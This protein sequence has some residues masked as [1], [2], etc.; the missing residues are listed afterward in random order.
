MPSQ[1]Q[2]LSPIIFVLTVLA[3]TS[4][5]GAK[6]TYDGPDGEQHWPKHYPFCGGVFQSPIDLQTQLFRYDPTLPPIEVWNYNLSSH[7]QLTLDNNGH[8]VQLSLPPRMYLS[9]GLPYR[10]SAAQLHLHW[11]SPSFPGG[12]EHTINGKQFAAELHVVHFNSDKYPNISI[13]V[14]KSDGLAVLGV[15]IEVGEFNPGFD[16]FLKYLRGIKYK[17]QQVQVPAFN[18]R[19]LLP[20]RL[21][22]Y[23]RY[24]GSLTTPPCYPSVLWTVFRT[25]VT[26]SVGQFQ[27]LN[28]AVYS[29]GMQES[30][31]VMLNGNYR[32]S[33]HPDDRVVLVSFQEGRGLH[34]TLPVT[35][36]LMR[37]QVI[38]QLLAGD[39]ADL[40]DE[41]IS[42]LL[43]NLSHKPSK[44]HAERKKQLSWTQTAAKQ[45]GQG[46]KVE[47]GAGG[48]FPV[49]KSPRAPGLLEDR[50]CYG[51]LEEKISQQLRR[52]H[53]E[54][55]LVD[56]L[57]DELFP[58]LNLRSYL[59]CR[60]DLSLDTVRQ[61]LRRRPSDEATELEQALT[62]IAHGSRR[63]PSAAR[64][65]RAF[66]KQRGR[67]QA[68][69]QNTHHSRARWN[70][71]PLWG[72]WED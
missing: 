64:L 59:A 3:I 34:G 13:A 5:H 32:K 2:P 67:S 66:T 31:L 23:Y 21:D 38:Q 46:W 57:K 4:C 26:I 22:Q 30:T 49:W 63:T 10:Y 17:D 72:E 24:D 25:P 27:A 6:W 55:Q 50:L 16:P 71:S 42:W 69:A 60:S 54:G 1:Y 51:S 18:I 58:D 48:F 29:S 62:R 47:G 56:A 35:S 53:A 65:D 11:G 52:A 28:S 61:I 39:L 33:Q 44:Q 41:G 43:P 37:R 45:R 70:H 15:L 40:A 19:D 68:A 20:A 12:S 8:S 9:G 7:E 14:D 36:P